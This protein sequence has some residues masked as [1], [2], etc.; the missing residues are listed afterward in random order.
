MIDRDGDREN[1]HFLN[2][3]DERALLELMGEGP[4][5]V[6]EKSCNCSLQ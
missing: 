3:V 5:E 4:E 1:V 6:V 2:A